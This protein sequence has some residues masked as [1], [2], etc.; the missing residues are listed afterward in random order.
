MTRM[1]RSIAW[2]ALLLCGLSFQTRA[3]AQDEAVAAEPFVT[4]AQHEAPVPR[5]DLVLT[6]LGALGGTAA[7]AAIGLGVFAWASSECRGHGCEITIGF[8]IG[9]ALLSAPWLISAGASWLGA[10]SGGSGTY[11]YSL[12]GA[13]LGVTPAIALALITSMVEEETDVDPLPLAITSIALAPIGMIIGAV[14]GY[15]VSA[16]LDVDASIDVAPDGSGATFSL[17]G[18]L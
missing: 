9:A 10:H 14:L 1:D 8:G 5:G 12:L 6:T 18:E 11:G 3:F 2:C 4:A 16:E 17:R 13:A 7:S 15:R